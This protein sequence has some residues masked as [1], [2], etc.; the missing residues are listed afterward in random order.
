MLG[1]VL[2]AA[3]GADLTAYLDRSEPIAAGWSLPVHGREVRAMARGTVVIAE[4]GRVEVAHAYF[5]GAGR[6]RARFVAT[7]LASISVQAG[8]VVEAGQALGR[9]KAARVVIDGQA[10][11]AF[12]AAHSAPIDLLAAE[13]AFVV[14]VDGRRLHALERGR[15][16]AQWEIAIGQA[17]GPKEVRGDLKTPRGMYFVTD[18]HHGKISGDWAEFYGEYWVKLNY[19]GPLD[20]ARGLD[21]GLIT[22][23]QALEIRSAWAK[24]ALTPQKT[25][26]GGGIGFHAWASEW[27]ADAGTSMS[28]GCVVLHPREVDAFYTRVQVGDPVVLR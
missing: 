27:E 17:E 11:A 6:H 20:A 14:D 9:G 7:G 10:P 16:V 15:E 5:E 22:A 28:F 2:A 19:P 24:R 4:A 13:R 12:I 23:D 8:A 21:A 1:F 25:R 3:L 18:R 26:L